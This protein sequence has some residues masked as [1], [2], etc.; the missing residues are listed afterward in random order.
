[1]TTTATTTNTTP[2]A[3]TGA[4][5]PATDTG[6]GP[7][8]YRPGATPGT[9]DLVLYAVISVHGRLTIVAATPDDAPVHTLHRRTGIGQ[10]RCCPLGEGITAWASAEVKVDNPASDRVAYQLDARAD[11][12]GSH[13]LAGVVVFTGTDPDDARPIGL[14]PVQVLLLRELHADASQWPTTD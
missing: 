14:T 1:M 6:L 5:R 8:T 3:P 2:T 13:Q 12:P 7:V 10:M 4:S 11:Y 9:P